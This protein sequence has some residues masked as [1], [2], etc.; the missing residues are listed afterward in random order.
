MEY[1]CCMHLISRDEHQNVVELVKDDI[2]Q[3]YG[4]PDC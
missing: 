4:K 2:Q 1:S 3:G